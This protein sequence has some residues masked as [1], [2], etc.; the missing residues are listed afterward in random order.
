MLNSGG[1]IN[2]IISF[3]I[4]KLG[5]IIRKIVINAQKIHVLTLIIDKIVI[6]DFLLHN[7]LENIGFFGMAYFI[8]SNI[9]IRFIEKEFVWTS[10]TTIKSVRSPRKVELFDKR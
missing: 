6:A 10:Y 7:K 3:Y 9:N 4:A 8:F 5:F 2:E 1:E